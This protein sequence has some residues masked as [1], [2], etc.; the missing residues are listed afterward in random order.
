MLKSI[1]CFVM[2]FQDITVKKFVLHG[3]GTGFFYFV[4]SIKLFP[5][6]IHCVKACRLKNP[7]KDVKNAA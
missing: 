2:F 6:H 3:S 4:I 5:F 7:S 1:N